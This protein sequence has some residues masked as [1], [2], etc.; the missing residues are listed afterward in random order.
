MLRIIIFNFLSIVILF[1]S[2]EAKENPSHLVLPTKG[3]FKHTHHQKILEELGISCTDCHNF[4]IKNL[5]KGPLAKPVEA[6]YIRAPLHICHQC[7]FGRVSLPRPNQ[8][9]ICHTDAQSLKPRN[10]LVAWRER[11]GKMAQI[12]R[13][14]CSKC[15]TQRTCDRCHLQVDTMNP[16]VHKANFRLY[17]SV[18]A[19]MNPQ[20]CTTCHANK[21]FCIDCHFG[22]KQ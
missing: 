13:D 3:L 16:T 15:H 6:G 12:D 20:S 5:E 22:R 18:E 10:H 7:H 8:C 17:H 11:H 2:L 1:S 19:R 14:Q 21:N 9:E 4:S